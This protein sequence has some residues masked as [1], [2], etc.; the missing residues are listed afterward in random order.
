M[1]TALP[2]AATSWSYEAAIVEL[3]ESVR[4]SASWQSAIVAVDGRGAWW[5]T[6]LD[7][8]RAGA[9]AVMVA[10]PQDVPSAAVAAVTRASVPILV[11]RH[12]L[13]PDVLGDALV[14]RAE[15]VATLVTVECAAPSSSLESVLR[16]A[17]RWAATLA[18]GPLR[19]VAGSSGMFLLEAQAPGGPVSVTLRTRLPAD[20]AQHPQ[21]K[22]MALGEVRTEVEWGRTGDKVAVTT[23]TAD[24]GLLA[25]VRY[26]SSARLTLRRAVEASRSRVGPNDIEMLLED[27]ELAV[28]LLGLHNQG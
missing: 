16:D 21:F 28:Q 18:G 6:V 3:S 17:V 15:T 13:R 9:L 5:D 19:S 22:V 25:P 11:E 14:L 24:G 26:E 27:R 7:A 4:P 1:K 8:Q 12:R 10:D 2:V 20:T 23:T